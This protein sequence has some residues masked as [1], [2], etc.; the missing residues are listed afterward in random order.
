MQL[1]K[2]S[3]QTFGITVHFRQ[4][5]QFARRDEYKQH[6]VRIRRSRLPQ[7]RMQLQNRPSNPLLRHSRQSAVVHRRVFLV[8]GTARYF[9]ERRFLAETTG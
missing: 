2:M 6:E 4:N 1:E 8:D 5:I 9:N 3:S 7:Q